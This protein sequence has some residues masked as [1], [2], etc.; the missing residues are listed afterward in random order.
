MEFFLARY[1]RE[2]G[3]LGGFWR[4]GFLFGTDGWV[5]LWV[6]AGFRGIVDE[7]LEA[8]HK[9]EDIVSACIYM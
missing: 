7:D 1:G 3:G 5:C 9:S 8:T 6:R 4:W 2:V